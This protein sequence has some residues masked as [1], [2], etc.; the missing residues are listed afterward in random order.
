MSCANEN[1]NNNALDSMDRIVVSI[2]GDFVCNQKCKEEYEKQRD[3]FFNVI[4]HSEK[5]T[6][7][8]LLGEL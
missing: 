2:D 7:K 5:L 3:Y 8:Y 4:I 1:C 6:K